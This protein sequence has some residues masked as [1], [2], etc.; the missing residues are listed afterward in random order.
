MGVSLFRPSGEAR[1]LP[2]PPGEAAGMEQC[3]SSSGSG[4]GGQGGCSSPVCLLHAEEKEEERRGQHVFQLED[5]FV[6]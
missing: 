5:E 2:W 4:V 1:L 6:G 3:C